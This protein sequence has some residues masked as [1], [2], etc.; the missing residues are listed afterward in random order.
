MH[1]G[2]EHLSKLICFTEVFDGIRTMLSGNIDRTTFLKQ[3]FDNVY[4]PFVSSD[5]HHE[6]QQP[7]SNIY[8][9]VVRS[10]S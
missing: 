6:R 2:I 1:L 5:S 8:T 3:E 4:M 7:C 10:P 9:P